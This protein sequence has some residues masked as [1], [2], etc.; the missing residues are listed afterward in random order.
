MT[1][2]LKG[3]CSRL[4]GALALVFAFTATTALAQTAKPAKNHYQFWVDLTKVNNDLLEVELVPPALKGE[5]TV[6]HLPKVIPGTYA[7]YDFGRFVSDF[8]ALDAKGNA[9]PVK[10]LDDNN[11]EITGAGKLARVRYKVQDTWDTDIKERFVFEVAGSDF[12]KDSIYA[13]NANCL[14]GYFDQ[15]KSYKYTVNVTKPQGF[16]GSTSLVPTSS[17]ATTDVWETPNYMD[18]VD[19]PIMYNKPD[20]TIL[21]VGGAQVLFSVYNTSKKITSKGVAKEVSRILEAAKA[22]LGGAL[23]VKK[24][25]F[26]IYVSTKPSKSGSFGAL[27]HSYSSFYLLP[28]APEEQMARTVRDVASHEFF[29]IVTP[30]NIHAKEIGDFDYIAPKMSEHLWLYE[31]VTEYNA[32]LSQV[33]AG[34]TTEADFVKTMAQKMTGNDQYRADTVSF[35]KMSRN[36]LNDP[37]DNYYGN[38]Y[39]KGALIGMCLDMKLRK[40]SGGKKGIQTLLADLSKFYGKEKSFDD[41]EL[42]DKITTL[43]YPEI[44]SFFTKH[45]EGTEPLP[46]AEVLAYAGVDYIPEKVAET[47]SMGIPGITLKDGALAVSKDTSRYDEVTREF[48]FRPGDVLYKLN[49]KE[50]TMATAQALFGELSKNIASTSKIEWVVKRQNAEGKEEEVT[51]KATPRMVPRKQK[52]ICTLAAEP[53]A[54]QLAFRQ[55]WLKNK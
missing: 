32:H 9:L 17:T 13:W 30:L 19:A 53:T 48:G 14:F 25:A 23:P 33:Q 54:E 49:G 11:W 28:E 10:K 45:V 21:N 47:M 34:I 12:E 55:A 2:S 50:F 3:L 6:Y 18:L 15:L 31:G 43:T 41:K 37:Y 46:Y 42:F 8:T 27:E 29:H 26:L 24:Y 1:V 7:T 52:H 16:Y 5:K 36:I 22:Y 35:T 40:L 20:T 38:V 51:L 39:Q 44:R 4:L